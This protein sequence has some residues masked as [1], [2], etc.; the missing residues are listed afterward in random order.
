MPVSGKSGVQQP[1][2]I[3]DGGLTG[4]ALKKV[5]DE[6]F[7]ADWAPDATGG[8]AGTGDVTQA[9][10]HAAMGLAYSLLNGGSE[11]G[12]RGPPGPAGSGATGATGAQGE[13]G[14]ALFMLAED[15]AEG[16]LGPPGRAGNDG[17]AGAAGATGPAGSL[18]TPGE[19]GNDGDMGPPG[20]PGTAGAA[21]ATG[22]PGAAG[23]PGMQGED[24]EP[25]EKGVPGT[26][27]AMGPIGPA[28]YM[29]A[30]DGEP[31]E[32][33]MPGATGATGATGAA[34]SSGSGGGGTTIIDFSTDI[35]EDAV[36]MI[37]YEIARLDRLFQE[38]RANQV[39]NWDSTAGTPRTAQLLLKNTGN[40]GAS[41]RAVR[42][43]MTEVDSGLDQ[44]SWDLLSSFGAFGIQS[45]DDA[46]ANVRSAL[47]LAKVAGSLA[48]VGAT[49]GNSTDLYPHLF[50]GV[51]Q[52]GYLMGSFSLATERFV[53]QVKRAQLTG[54]MRATLAGTSR[55]SVSN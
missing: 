5:S 54:A 28:L 41:A 27:G 50:F 3:P 23:A 16:D 52:Q 42:I 4:E 48:I 37:P 45:S 32:M 11:D 18:G 30:E 40:G 8:G 29:L 43:R 39:I 7:D 49:H 25:G 47:T 53:H 12:E 55:L 26:P 46:G 31:G 9:Q 44:K 24:G 33:G 19:D 10:L 35:S 51:H 34:G 14:P 38:F 36:P 22:S 20:T 1:V 6:D 13:I 15:G 2:G 21:G 17:T